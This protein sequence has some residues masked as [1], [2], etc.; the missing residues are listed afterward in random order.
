MTRS[1]E[2]EDTALAGAENRNR[3]RLAVGAALLLAAAIFVIDLGL[4]LGVAGGVP[5]VAVV[6][7][8]LLSPR[9]S[10]TPVV[11]LVVSVL[12]VLGYFL[13]PEGAV[14][15][16]VLTNRGLALFV[17]WITAAMCWAW[18]Q[19]Q[20]ALQ[21][22]GRDLAARLRETQAAEAEARYSEGRL[23]MLA[24]NVPALFGFVGPDRCYRFVNKGYEDLFGVPASSIVGRHIRDLLGREGYATV[25]R[26]VESALNG[27]DVRF[28]LDLPIEFSGMRRLDVHYVPQFDERDDVTGFY[29]LATDVTEHAETIE[30]LQD[31]EAALRN[32]VDSATDGIV[33][34]SARGIIESF[35]PAAEAMFGYRESDVIGRNVNLIMASPHKEKHDGYIERY[36]R[37]GEA[38]II[39]IGREVHGVR[40]DGTHFP[41]EIGVSELKDGE[42]KFTAI[43]HDLSERKRAEDAVRYQRDFAENLIDVAPMIVLVLD[44]Q[45]RIVRYN[46]FLEQL[47]GWSLE[48]TRGANWFETFLPADE[49]ERIR[50]VHGETCSG[51]ETGGKINRILTKGGEER[52]VEWFN[53]TLEGAD[54]SDTGVLAVG[55]DVT[56]ARLLEE[57]F[58][59]SQKLEAVG[60]LA[61]GIAHD[62]NNL[63]MGILGCC[64][65]AKQD[66]SPAHL[67]EI[68]KAAERGARLTRQLLMF[69]RRR[70]ESPRPMFLGDAIRDTERMIR[71]LV[72]ED[73]AMHIDVE[74]GVG[75]VL[76][77]AGAIEQ[78]LM[79]LVVNARD[80]MPNGGE[81]SIRI[82]ETVCSRDDT[83]VLLQG[84]DGPHV[85]LIVSDTGCGMD[86]D[87]KA[88]VFEPFFTTKPEG[89]GTGLGL[90]SVYGII[91][92]LG[93][94]IHL[95][96]AVGVGTEI[97]IHLPR[98]EV[99][100]EDGSARS[101]TQSAPAAGGGETVL[102][103]EDERLVRASVRQILK[104]LGYQVVDAPNPSEA[105][106]RCAEL[107]RD[108]DLLLTDM[109]MP[110]GMSGSDL[111]RELTRQRPGL[112]TVFM[113]A[114]PAEL[115][116]EQGRID[117]GQPTLEKP[118]DEEQLATVVRRVLDEPAPK[119]AGP[120]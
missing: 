47:T 118:F 107:E 41:L 95:D 70:I 40:K 54:Y 102:L 1:R 73:I 94:H 35:N 57:E 111:A 62:F 112:R 86:E 85:V 120:A 30:A 68:E 97:R 83:G 31:S 36:F 59:Q 103:V 78:V 49:R 82:A 22:A 21:E 19:S 24:D 12:T 100:P 33:I 18:K 81:L 17:I 5:Y 109:V 13:S 90:A 39:G 80:A 105:L 79:N 14:E 92:H 117:A 72:G 74:P 61:G 99:A 26:H 16:V 88:R 51:V 66:R 45:G 44:G 43:L 69:S 37:T 7:L 27:L 23:R 114:Y 10:D 106:E 76:A 60:R 115:L 46:R 58:R 101:A 110:G 32:I 8:T 93:G 29:V 63:L 25:E 116:V 50:T 34:I 71:Q 9:R 38:R 119:T 84:K 55:R 89:E 6:A 67:E 91:G 48:E 56:E 96:S 113:S 52:Y 4:P 104:Q 20:A 2:R 75:P 87:T 15:W 98:S 28:E 11:A 53:T 77:D 65:S 108:P 64:R 3:R 42:T